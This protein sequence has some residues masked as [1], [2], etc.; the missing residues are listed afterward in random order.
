MY[1][2]VVCCVF[3]VCFYNLCMFCVAAAIANKVFNLNSS[4][5]TIFYLELAV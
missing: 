3:C 1:A 5:C 4:V 2:C